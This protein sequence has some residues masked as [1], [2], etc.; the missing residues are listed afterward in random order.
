MSNKTRAVEPSIS[1]IRICHYILVPMPFFYNHL[2]VLASHYYKNRSVGI[3]QNTSIEVSAPATSIHPST[4]IKIYMGGCSS[5]L[6]VASLSGPL[7]SM[8]CCRPAAPHCGAHAP[9]SAAMPHVGGRAPRQSRSPG[10]R[11]T[12]MECA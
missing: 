11:A 7:G 9:L 2:H 4:R 1:K 3:V 8:R 10:P 5:L 6:N 12:P